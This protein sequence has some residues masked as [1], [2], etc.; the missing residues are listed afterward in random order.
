MVGSALRHAVVARTPRVWV[1]ASLVLGLALAMLVGLPPGKAAAAACDPPV[2]NEIACENTKTGNPESEWGISGAGSTA[3]QGFATDI[4]VNR[5]STIGFKVKTTA[6]NYRMDIYRMGYYGGLGARKITSIDVT[7][8]TSQPA[9]LTQSTTGLIDCGNWTQTASWAVPST[10]VSGIYFANLVSGTNNSH[11][12]FIVRDDASTSDVFFQTSDTTWQAYNNYGGNSLYTG[13]PAGRAYKVSYNRPFNT[14]QG[15]EAHDFVWNAEY[16]AVRFLEANGYNV[17]YTTGVDSERRGALIRNHKLFLSV[18]HDEYW[19]GG[20]RTNVEAARDAGVHLAFMSGNEVFWKTRW[21][22]SIAAGT[23]ANRTLVTY[24]E[25]LDNAKTDPA[26]ATTWTGTWRD[27]RFSPPADGGRP[28]NSLTGTLFKANCCVADM[29]GNATDGQLR[30]WRN[31]RVATLTGNQTTV[32]GSNILGYEWDES[33][34]NGYAP[35]GLVKLSKTT[36]NADALQNYGSSY[37]PGSV[38]HNLTLY[39]ASSGALVFGAGSV[40]WTWGLDDNHCCNTGATSDT[41][42]KQATVNLFADMGIQPSSL[43]SGLVAAT[44]SSDTAAPTST[45]SAPADGA[46]VPVGQALTISGTATDAG[47]GKVGAVEVSV[48]DGLSWKQATGRASWSYTFTPGASGTLKIRTRAT[49]DS[50]RMET[51]AAA[52]TVTVGTGSGGGSCPCSIFPASSTPGVLAD[53]DAT[54]IEL[55]VKFRTSTAGTITGLRFYKSSTNTGTHVGT[56]WTSAGT[57]L[58]TATFS[59]ESAS[60]WQQVQFANPVPVSANTTYVASYF[61]PN[62]HYSTTEGFFSSPASNGPLTA[63]QDNADGPNG[64]YKYGATGFPTLGFNATNYWVDVV[65][66]QTTNDTTKP[67]VA[68]KVPASGATGVAK[69]TTI[70]ATFSEPVTASSIAMTVRD[71]ANAVVAGTVA[72]DAPTQKATFTPSAS[73]AD[74]TTYTVSVSG[75]ADAAGNVMDPVSWSFTTAAAPPPDTTPPTVTAKTPAA[76]ATGVDVSTT[77]TATFS[78]AVQASTIVLGLSGPGGNVAGATAY[79]AGTNTVTFTPS[80]SLAY[81]TAYTVSL[82]G[83]KDTAGN[84]MSPV[85]WSF[86]TASN[87][88]PCTIWASSATPDI[89]AD[90]DTATIE[91]GVKFRT[92]VAGKVTGVRFYK[93]AGNTGTHIGSLWTRTGTKL[94]SV[95]FTGETATGWQQANFSTPVSISANTTYMV[96]YLAPAGHYAVSESYFASAAVTRGP[97]TAL[98][99]NTDGVNGAYRYTSTS[100]FPN[101]GFKSSNYWVDV[102]FTTP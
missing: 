80:A 48:D 83:A 51:P 15:S 77:V 60:G 57:A 96:S 65:Y 40:Q 46:T 29:E 17:S 71:A 4:S 99:N 102:V 56:L 36:R 75:A 93:G 16:P 41:A 20:Q 70:S 98:K 49:D 72:Y 68:T 23:A 22:N 91:V 66:D 27:P 90:T 26:G 18:G 2:S 84:A 89:A 45:I 82:S 19:S 85:T 81:S 38:T 39:R 100:A 88:C 47:G 37:A 5:G 34:D 78:E 25:T 11:I 63:L 50:L 95:T 74:S 94:A 13:S 31:T 28:E 21:E 14:N 43:Q 53:S 62:G 58:A 76:N 79:N 42:V 64:V 61:A 52:R 86:T 3:I 44:A 35:A 32:L 67:T 8:A 92:S 24:K 69:N 7:T 12:T 101:K 97:L 59:G 6:S 33:P 54:S 55:G 10:A 9:C 1:T 30:F 73:L 87:G